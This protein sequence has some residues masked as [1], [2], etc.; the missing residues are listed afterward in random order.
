VRGSCGASLGITASH[1][2]SLGAPKV[3]KSPGVQASASSNTATPTVVSNS[4]P[5]LRTSAKEVARRISQFWAVNRLTRSS[6]DPAA[7]STTTRR[8]IAW[9]SYVTCMP[10][11]AIAAQGALTV[12]V[13]RSTDRAR[14]VFGLPS[15]GWH[16][17]RLRRRRRREFGQKSL[18]F[19]A[20]GRI[21]T[22]GAADSCRCQAILGIRSICIRRDTG[23][24]LS[25]VTREGG[26]SRS[27]RRRTECDR[28]RQSTVRSPARG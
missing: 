1:S 8:S 21:T 14:G 18:I 9:A 13:V 25:R 5:G 15:A 19:W 10:P 24:L 12:G 20:R 27:V 23:F 6:E 2:M 16:G 7:C 26:R 28:Q 17:V 22:Q 3:K 4:P 11:H